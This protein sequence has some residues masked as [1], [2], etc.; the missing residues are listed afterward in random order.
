MAWGATGWPWTGCGENPMRESYLRLALPNKGRLRDPALRLLREAGL[1]FE[2]TDR[3]LSVSVRNAAIELLFVRTEDVVEL[4]TDGVADLG[5][6]GLDLIEESGAKGNRVRVLLRLGFGRC[7]LTVAIPADA[8]RDR[9]EDFSGLRVAT[10]H[11][12]LTE[13]FF[14]R[15]GVRVDIVRLR[16]S[17]EVAPK[18]GVADAVADLVSTGSTMLVNGLRPVLPVLSS[19]AVLVGRSSDL[20][21]RTEFETVTT[22]I[23]SVL[24]GRRRRYLL[25]NA[26]EETLQAIT[27]LIPGLEA[28]TVVPLAEDG[29]VAIHSVVER[30]EVWNL[31]PR[32]RAAG[33]RDILVLPIGQLVP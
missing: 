3:A 22:A 16:G 6:S 4:V 33:G 15:H 13:Q 25:L 31:L 27:E 17:V 1:S 5:I 9:P 28:P 10:S 23:E 12:N 32:L 2:Q 7:E 20:S 30:D 8:A 21:K 18:L 29:M 11:P 14:A 24:A 26:P 19:E